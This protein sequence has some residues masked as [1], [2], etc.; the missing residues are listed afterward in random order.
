[1]GV[2]SR[3]AGVAILGI[4]GM[5]GGIIT[6]LLGIGGLVL[7][8]FLQGILNS[9]GL[10]GMFSNLASLVVALV[11][12][13]ILIVGLLY[14]LISWGL[15]TG[16]NWARIIWILF[17]ILGIL[18]ALLILA[19]GG[20]VVGVVYLIIEILIVYYLTRS[21]VAAYFK[22]QPMPMQPK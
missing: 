22:R 15:F 2:V 19:G 4:L 20:Y 14:L 9:A 16:K 3:P 11:S 7:S 17:S 1:L 21:G 10:S 13:G 18:L 12:V 5:L 8:A 6:L